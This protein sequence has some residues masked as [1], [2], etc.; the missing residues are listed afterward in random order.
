MGILIYV[1]GIVSGVLLQKQDWFS[2]F[3]N[4]AIDYIKEKIGKGK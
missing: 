2:S 3:I 1:L 4:N